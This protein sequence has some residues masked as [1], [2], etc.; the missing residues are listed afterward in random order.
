[1]RRLGRRVENWLQ[2][3]LAA[4][5]KRLKTLDWI[6][7]A[8]LAVFGGSYGGFA[9]LS[10]MS[11]LP[12]LWAAD[13][14]ICG[15]ANLETLVRSLPPD[16]LMVVRPMFGDPDTDADD[17]RR[18][19]PVTY[20]DQIVQRVRARGIEVSY[21]VFDDEGHGFTNRDNDIKG[22]STVAEF[23]ACHLCR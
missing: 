2:S 21:L 12:E 22:N 7:P 6:D 11:R 1:M 8:R 5:G 9:A 3:S 23:F 13:V 14:S 18:R 16:W 15:P 10:C 4:L 19:S 17:M 20:A